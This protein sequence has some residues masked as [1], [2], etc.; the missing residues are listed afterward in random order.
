V[1]GDSLLRKHLAGVLFILV[2]LI[3]LAFFLI[4]PPDRANRTLFFP[5]TTELSL[6]GER[7]LLPRGTDERA[8]EFLVQD[9]ILGPARI[10]H[11]RLL[12]RGTEINALLLRNATLYVDLSEDALVGSDAVRIPLDK[13]LAGLEH[14]IR[15]NFR[16]VEEIIVTIDGSIPFV[17]AFRTQPIGN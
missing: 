10:E 5:G 15:Y 12:P 6:R 16:R 2:L 8:I 17:P 7:R 11:G 9:Q 4:F 13:A 3:S 1:I 14:A